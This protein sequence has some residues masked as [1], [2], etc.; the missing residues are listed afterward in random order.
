MISVTQDVEPG[1]ACSCKGERRIFYAAVRFN[2]QSSKLLN[3]HVNKKSDKLHYVL[4][5][6]SHVDD[7]I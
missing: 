4:Y 1:G 5:N 7:V 3:L 6:N 2:I